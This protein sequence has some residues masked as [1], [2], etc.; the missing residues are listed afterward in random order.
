MWFLYLDESGD[1]GFDFVNK[2]PS[3]FFTVTILAVHGI[4]SHRA[5]INAVKHTIKRK[6]HT[7]GNKV[8]LKGSKTSITVKKYFYEQCKN[9][10]FGIYSITLNKKRLYDHLTRDKERVYNYVAR[11]V[12]NKI[13]VEMANTRICLV[14]DKSKARPEIQEFNSY[15]T[16]ELKGRVDPNVPIDIYHYI[17]DERAGIQAADMFCWGI[18]RKYERKDDEWFNIFWKGKGRYISLYLP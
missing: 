12:M 5:I 16:R 11:L 1:L 9:I 3:R 13:P 10:D 14:V 8:E 15:I 2:K 18:Y 7:R 4:E 17:S 6:L